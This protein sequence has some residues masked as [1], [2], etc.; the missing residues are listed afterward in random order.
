MF[1][2]GTIWFS[3][4]N[5]GLILLDIRGKTYWR[6][7]LD[8]KIQN[9]FQNSHYQLNTTLHTYSEVGD[10]TLLLEDATLNF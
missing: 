3:N 9:K 2:K 10:S 5:I 1:V 7:F 6:M 4:Q 8:H